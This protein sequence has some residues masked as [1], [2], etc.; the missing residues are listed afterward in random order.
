VNHREASLILLIA[1]MRHRIRSL[2][3]LR[4]TSGLAFVA[5]VLLG[6]CAAS[7][8]EATRT[9]SLLAAAG[10]HAVKPE[11]P[12]QREIFAQMP[13]NTLEGGLIGGK[14]LYSYKD[15][16][17]DAVYVGGETEFQQYEVLLAKWKQANATNPD[18]RMNPRKPMLGQEAFGYRG[19]WLSQD[20]NH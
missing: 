15:P 8:P 18:Q 14:Q 1:P 17:K 5:A 3:P 9:R 19:L 12:E 20:M 2:I 11:T 16:G 4:W 6:A 7:N 13:A 10:F